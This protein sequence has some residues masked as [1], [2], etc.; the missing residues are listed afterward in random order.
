M[1]CL[2]PTRHYDKKVNLIAIVHVQKIQKKSQPHTN[3][4]RDFCQSYCCPSQ[5]MQP[6]H[7]NWIPRTSCTS[8]QTPT[9]SICVQ[10]PQSPH[11]IALRSHSDEQ[12]TQWKRIRLRVHA[13]IT[14]TV[15]R[16]WLLSSPYITL[17]VNYAVTEDANRLV[18]C[19]LSLHGGY[20]TVVLANNIYISLTIQLNCSNN[21]WTSYRRRSWQLQQI[22]QVVRNVYGTNGPWYEWSTRGTNSPWYE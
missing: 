21:I 15:R 13:M 1:P 8:S 6:V 7:I 10:R 16:Q 4:T 9:Q 19:L 11:C 14:T 17:L 3:L 20:A 18:L 22:I 5:E 12:T 2:R